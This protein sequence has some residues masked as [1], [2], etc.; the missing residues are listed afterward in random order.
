M[1]AGMQI[2]IMRRNT[3]AMCRGRM[4]P[5]LQCAAGICAV[6]LQGL[7]LLNT[8]LYKA[9]GAKLRE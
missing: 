3:A 1:T 6:S 5:N 7:L 4:F 2:C 9:V 8:R